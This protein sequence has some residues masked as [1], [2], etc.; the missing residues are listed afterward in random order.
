MLQA[1][2]LVV[3]CDDARMYIFNALGVIYTVTLFS[4]SSGLQYTEAAI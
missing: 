3:A 4:S 2:T 1:T